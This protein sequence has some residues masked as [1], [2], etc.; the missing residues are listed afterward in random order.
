MHAPRCDRQ[1]GPHPE[2]QKE[3]TS[4]QGVE[5][6]RFACVFPSVLCLLWVYM[7]KY[8]LLLLL[9]QAALIGEVLWRRS[10]AWGN[11]CDDR[12][13]AFVA[14]VCNSFPAV[15]TRCSNKTCSSS[16]TP[17]KVY[18]VPS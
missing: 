4:W 2:A 18:K 11:A 13:D 12:L 7:Y 1:G 10:T 17:R 15:S 9:A 8:M 5:T 16:N 3:N 14:W 6:H